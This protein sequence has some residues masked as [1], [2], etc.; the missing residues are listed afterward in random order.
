M[1]TSLSPDRYLELIRADTER[2]LAV[3]ERDV[4]AAVPTCPGWRVADL[5][6]HVAHVYEHKVRVMA[7]KEW[8]KE[9]PPPE[10]VGREPTGFLR[11]AYEHLLDEFGR[12]DP[13][14]QTATFGEDDTVTFWLRRM[15]LEVAVH[16]LDGELAQSDPTPIPV[17]ISLD[18]VDEML[19]VFVAG[20]WKGETDHPV[21][22]LVLIRADGH[23]WSCDVTGTTVT[24]HRAPDA[25]TPDAGTPDA[26]T[27]DVET[28][29]GP[30]SEA[31]PALTVS[32][33]ADAMFLWVWGRG[34]DDR[35]DVSGDPQ[36]LAELRGRL[37]EAA[38]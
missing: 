33:P 16:R 27:R 8:P 1:T 14:E 28:A 7:N 36:V 32:G 31:E 18:G 21:D 19:Q 29:T 10:W 6:D 2:L 4:N 24:V 3:A 26:G 22:A 13:A 35:V 15:A 20:N 34:G 12:H 17:D 5:L 37:V 23:A 25:R 30:D 11:E 9:W 38:Q